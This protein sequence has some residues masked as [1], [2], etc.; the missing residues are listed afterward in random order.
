[1]FQSVCVGADVPVL[2]FQRDEAQQFVSW[3]GSAATWQGLV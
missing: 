2:F 3:V 1:M